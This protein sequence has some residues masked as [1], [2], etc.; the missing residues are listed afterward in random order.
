MAIDGRAA[1]ER[2]SMAKILLIE[3]DASARMTIVQLLEEA[4]HQ[5]HW[6]VNGLQGMAMFRGWQPDLIV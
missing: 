4:S 1:G 6:A 5:V 3:D 2:F